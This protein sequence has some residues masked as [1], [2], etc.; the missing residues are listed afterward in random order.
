M[1]DWLDKNGYPTK[2]ALETI[3][4]WT[5]KDNSIKE[6]IEFLQDIWNWGDQ[7]LTVKK[8]FS[9]RQFKRSVMK[10][11]MHT[12]GWSG[13]ESIIEAIEKQEYGLFFSY[14]KK[15]ERGGH[16]YFEV[17]SKSWK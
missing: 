6:F 10:I 1:T 5:V 8:G 13:N 11:E 4:K 15:T 16:Y 14:W 9:E 3:S 12:G 2:K 7:M 17:P